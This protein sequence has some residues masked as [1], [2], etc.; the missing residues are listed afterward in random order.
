MTGLVR[1]ELIKAFSTR[2]AWAMPLAMFLVTAA[3]TAIGAFFLVYAE[4][5][6][7]DT[8]IRA[9]ETM[10][11]TVLV[12]MVYTGAV[13]MGYLLTLVL[14]I[15]TMGAEYRHRTLTATL[16]AVPRRGRMILAKV[17]GLVVVVLVNGLAHLAGALLAGGAVLLSADLSLAPDPGDLVATMLR[18]LLVLVLWGLIG[19]GLGVLIPNQVVA[20]FV[21]VAVAF[22]VEPLLGF[23]ITFWDAVA[24]AAR[25][26]PSQ[27][28]MSTLNIFDGADAA[29]TQALGGAENPLAW[30]VAGLVLLAYAGVM[31]LLGWVLTSR[32]DV[33]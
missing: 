1:S 16:Q 2:T 30:W 32:R 14:G 8:T 9:R 26:F 13:Q 4:L 10:D 33:G 15:L 19:F 24:D 6:V 23:G 18:L 29:T 20:L 17:L 11:E 22:I 21:G 27:L 31:T 7:G 25:F 5:P 12:R 3:F 28:T